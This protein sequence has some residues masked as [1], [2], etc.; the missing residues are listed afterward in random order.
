[1]LS[2]T[3]RWVKERLPLDAVIRRSLEEEMV[4]GTSYAYV[5]GNSVPLLFRLPIPMGL[6]QLISLVPTVDHGFDMFKHFKIERK[7]W[8][9]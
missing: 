6:F 8:S 3:M 4:D 7:E 9:A 1:M 2:W 5:F